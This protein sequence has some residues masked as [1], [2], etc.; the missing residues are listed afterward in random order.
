MNV[1]D[2]KSRR[3]RLFGAIIHGKEAIS[4]HNHEDFLESIYTSEEA[5]GCVSKIILSV[6]GLPALQKAMRLSLTVNFLDNHATRL[7]EFL[8]QKELVGIGGGSFLRKI[9][10][11]IVEPPVFWD[12]YTQAFRSG[13]LHLTAHAPFAWLLLQLT[14]LPDSM[15]EAY[16]E[17]A[18]DPAILN[19]L[20]SSLSQAAR[21]HAQRIQLIVDTRQIGSS[22]DCE[23]GPGGRHDNDFADFRKIVIMPTADE[24]DSVKPPFLRPLKTLSN[25]DDK[26]NII[27]THLDSQFRLY[28]ED[29][30]YEIREDTQFIHDLK[31]GKH[32]S[33]VV[34]GLRLVDVHYEP[35]SNRYFQKCR[36]GIKLKCRWDLW[37]EVSFAD[38]DERKQHVINCRKTELPHQSNVCLLADGDVVAFPRV[39]RVED[40][41]ALMPPIIVVQLE[42]KLS[43]TKTLLKLK[44]ATNIQLVPIDTPIFAYE[45]VLK[46]LQEKKTLPLSK[47]ILEWNPNSSMPMRPEVYPAS[48]VE[49]IHNFAKKNDDLGPPLGINKSVILDDAQSKSLVS[50]LTQRVSLIQ[51][52]PGE[53]LSHQPHTHRINYYPVVLQGLAN[54]S[55]APSSQNAFTITQTKE[56]LSSVTLITL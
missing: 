42:D 41:L 5:A 56:S 26:T 7:L 20:H 44:T 1:Y 28:R 33:T 17:R 39:N 11:A 16:I 52:P 14:M 22:I 4:T 23:L 2:I 18:K 12:T 30:M 53:C 3:I 6:Y 45:P 47:E 50:G 10:L 36:W 24:L 21:K 31:Q 48:I 13:V 32:K 49:M 43:T 9:V 40:L 55:L 27:S 29:M 8:S 19:I 37:N 51:G 25:S 46:A 54:R 34:D 38:F 15:A 35:Q